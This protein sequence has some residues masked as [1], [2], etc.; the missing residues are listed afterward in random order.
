MA[1]DALK[2][3]FMPI[4]PFFN[5]CQPAYQLADAKAARAAQVN[6]DIAAHL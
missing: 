1:R 2:K 4:A 3:I 6:D 5:F